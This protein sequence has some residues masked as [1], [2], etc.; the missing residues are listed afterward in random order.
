MKSTT[1]ATE[2]SAERPG[3]FYTGKPR[4]IALAANRP[5][6]L[7]YHDGGIMGHGLAN[8]RMAGME[9]EAKMSQPLMF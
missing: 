3:R 9:R 1:L 4:L 6:Q 7:I 8:K 2:N 5:G